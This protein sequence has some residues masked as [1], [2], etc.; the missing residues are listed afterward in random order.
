MQLGTSPY[1]DFAVC[2]GL[3]V[4]NA[5]C[6]VAGTVAVRAICAAF[7]SLIVQGF[8]R[9]FAF[10]IFGGAMFAIAL[11]IGDTRPVRD[12]NSILGFVVGMALL[13]PLIL[14]TIRG[15]ASA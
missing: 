8:L 10:A 5:A 12:A 2:A 4:A 7:P 15:E 3:G 13:L 6:L 1:V 9:V 11:V 14:K